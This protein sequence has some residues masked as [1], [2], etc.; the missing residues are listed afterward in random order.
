MPST[1][2]SSLRLELQATGE[3]ANTWGTKTNNNLNLIEQA[4]AGYVKITLTSASATY[5]LDIAD[6]SASDGRNAF[7]EF[8]G[9]VASAI[10]VVVPD[11]E[12]GYWVKNSATGSNLTF[13]TSSGTGFT[14][15]TNQWVF[16]ITDGASAVN[17]TPTSLT[18]YARLASDQTFTGLNTFT[19]TVNVQA[20]LSVTGNAFVSGVTTLASAVDIKG[21][22]SVA[23]TLVVG[24]AA[25]FNST[26]S[27][28]STLVVGPGAV[29]T[30]SISTTGDTNT[31]IWFPAADTLA[32]ST[33]GSERMRI[34]SAGNVGIGTSPSVRLEVSNTSGEISRFVNTTGGERIHLYP[35]QAASTARVESQNADL[36]VWAADANPV[37]VG[38]SN[39]ERMR[40][41][42]AGYVG[43][44]T[45][46]PVSNLTISGSQTLIQNYSTY[47]VNSYY[48]T[49]WRYV[50]NGMAWGIGNNF[51][52]PSN[53]VCIA[54]AAVNAGGAGAALTW[55]PRLNIDSSGNV[56]IGTTSPATKLEVKGTGFVAIQVSG[57]STSESQIRFATNTAARVSQQANQAL[58]FD[59]NASERMRINSSGNVAI[60][61]TAGSSAATE[62]LTVQGFGGF[63]DRA[64][65]NPFVLIGNTGS[66][67]GLVGTYSN[68]ALEVRTNNTERMRITAAGNVQI[69]TA[70]LATTAT[71]GFLYIPT[72]AGTPTGVP[73]AI[74]GLAP[75]VIN[76]TNNKLY[77]YSGGAWRDAGP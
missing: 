29:G 5:T 13:R 11:V 8:V 10:S 30:P 55:L 43:I 60:G 44:A 63:G 17:T 67:A 57:D 6:A 23:T 62:Q 75:L 58:L 24:G 28:S 64:T 53:G 77:F 22:T 70:A 65:T 38:T 49:A 73:T 25:T 31:G 68:H 18:G 12:K 19:S 52:G 9:T 51:G 39:T 3:N 15:P 32:A 46:S 20:A 54:A 72:C 59:T 45:S 40:I 76:T 66:G 36:Q 4:V 56:G 69:G 37:I 33:G 27:V 50:E 7:I 2:S 71:D 21:A 26:V 14:L 16:A 47:L 34:N 48:D 74:T 41:T 35:R 1:Y 42:S 61:T